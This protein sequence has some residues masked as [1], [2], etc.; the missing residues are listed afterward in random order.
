MPPRM[1]FDELQE[2]AKRHGIL[3][4]SDEVQSRHGPDGEDVGLR[5]FRCRAGHPCRRPRGSRAACRC[6]AMI[7]RADLM[8][9][10]PGAH[11]STFGGNPVAVAA[12]L[13]TIELLEEGLMGNA[14]R[15]AR[16]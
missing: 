11:A 3:L 16:T 12:A 15:W 14:G 13:A 6:R 9:W 7:A 4:V 10:K 5:A 2:I 8:T 1:F